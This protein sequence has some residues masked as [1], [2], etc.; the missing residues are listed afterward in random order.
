M[1]SED[2]FKSY[3]H[4]I[5]K[6]M[7]DEESSTYIQRLHKPSVCKQ[8]NETWKDKPLCQSISR[9]CIEEAPTTLK[10]RM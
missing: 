2:V 10:M 7:V 4:V 1:N 3:D 9:I 8:Q 5:G 6:D